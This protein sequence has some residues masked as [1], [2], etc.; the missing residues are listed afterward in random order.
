[1]DREMVFVNRLGNEWW[2]REGRGKKGKKGK[3]KDRYD[4]RDGGS[5]KERGI[6][7]KIFYG[8]ERNEG[9]KEEEENNP[10]KTGHRKQT[11]NGNRYNHII[12]KYTGNYLLDKIEE[13]TN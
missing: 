2:I 7:V 1:M 8:W 3:K 4:K 12:Y 10:R 11:R 9:G 6:I 13:K 5:G